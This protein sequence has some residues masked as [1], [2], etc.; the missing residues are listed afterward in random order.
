MLVIFGISL[1]YFV[2]KMSTTI[3]NSGIS[4]FSLCATQ[5]IN[6]FNHHVNF[7]FR[8]PRADVCNLCNE[9]ELGKRGTL[10]TTLKNSIVRIEQMS[11]IHASTVW[12]FALWI[13]FCTKFSTFKITGKLLVFI[14]CMSIFLWL[15][16]FNV[17]VHDTNTRYMFHFIERALKKE[18]NTVCNLLWHVFDEEFKKIITIWYEDIF[19]PL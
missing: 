15:H 13:W 8:L 9:Y 7:L 2:L 3:F 1:P 10:Y 5:I 19:I 11:T 4:T 14:V 17:D 16:V 18:A 6:D 12:N